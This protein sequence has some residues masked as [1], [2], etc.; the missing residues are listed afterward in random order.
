M[1]GKKQY[2]E[3]REIIKQYEEQL[4]NDD[5]KDVTCWIIQNIVNG[6]V[7]VTTDKDYANRVYTSGEYM[8]YKSHIINPND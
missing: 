6:D 1:I 5:I 7:F 8:M 3:A 4:K 2:K